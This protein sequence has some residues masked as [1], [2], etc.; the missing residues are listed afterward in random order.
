WR[1]VDRGHL[2][3]GNGAGDRHGNG[4]GGQHGNNA[5]D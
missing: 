3:R 2:H 1:W 4:T 5:G